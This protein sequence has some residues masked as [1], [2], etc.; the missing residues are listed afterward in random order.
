MK[1]TQQA[2]MKYN[3]KAPASGYTPPEH[4]RIT[5]R[6]RR[7]DPAW[8]ILPPQVRL[9]SNSPTT[10]GTL[11]GGLPRTL[12]R[13][14]ASTR[15]DQRENL[16]KPALLED[17]T[18]A[19]SVGLSS[20]VWVCAIDVIIRWRTGRGSARNIKSHP[21]NIGKSCTQRERVR[22]YARDAGNIRTH[23]NRQN[24]SDVEIG[25]WP[26]CDATEESSF[27]DM[28]ISALAAVR[29]IAL[30]LRLTTFLTMATSKENK[31]RTHGCLSVSLKRISQTVIKFF[32]TTVTTP[33]DSMV[34]LAL[35]NLVSSRERRAI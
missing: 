25:T 33:N 20:I 29:V 13:N 18:L 30:F 23:L 21:T 17:E 24:V 5:A 15:F 12:V 3:K 6:I 7:S 27:T 10:K 26:P 14:V 8:I 19:E 22:G 9:N 11:K 34:V 4:G 28:G 32:A 2:Q 16:A 1:Q 31:C 35:I